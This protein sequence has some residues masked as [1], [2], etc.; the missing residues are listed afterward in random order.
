MERNEKEKNLYHTVYSQ[1][2]LISL[3]P[4]SR[5][6]VLVFRWNKLKVS[7]YITGLW[8]LT[9]DSLKSPDEKD[10]FNKIVSNSCEVHTISKKKFKQ[11][12]KEYFAA[13]RNSREDREI[14][15]L[16]VGR[17]E[18]DT[19]NKEEFAFRA[20]AHD[21]FCTYI[22]RDNCGQAYPVIQRADFT[23]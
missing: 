11:M 18:Q 9:L 22:F 1:K 6:T 23:P 21:R 20:F 16:L 19:D 2:N 7:L 12:I 3:E 17:I 15:R 14:G 13:N 4:N 10:F 5:G 8:H